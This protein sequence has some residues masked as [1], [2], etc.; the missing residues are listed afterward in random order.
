MTIT[1][2]LAGKK[3]LEEIESPINGKLQVIRDLAWGTY[4]VGGGL[5]QS[6]GILEKIWN[7][8]LKEIQNTS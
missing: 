3:V 5:T 4:V 1:D 2:F 6:G 7:N 8:T